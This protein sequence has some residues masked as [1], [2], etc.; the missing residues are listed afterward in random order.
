VA[1]GE[2]TVAKDQQVVSTLDDVTG[3]NVLA[4]ADS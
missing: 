4:Y 1:A 2:H 3:G